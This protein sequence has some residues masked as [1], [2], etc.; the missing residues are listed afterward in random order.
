MGKDIKKIF[1]AI[2]KKHGDMAI[3]R[4]CVKTKVS[5]S[6]AIKLP[7]NEENILMIIEALEELGYDIDFQ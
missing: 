5:E 3:Y 7:D 4:V 2:K 1:A 6:D